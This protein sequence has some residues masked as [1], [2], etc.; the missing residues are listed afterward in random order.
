MAEDL[1]EA[2]LGPRLRAAIAA[3]GSQ[4]AFA[5]R[6]G[7]AASFI[8]EVAG[9]RR[10]FTDRILAAM[11]LRKVT[12]YRPLGAAG[13][14][15]LPSGL[16]RTDHKTLLWL[17]PDG[18]PRQRSERTGEWRPG[19]ADLRRMRALRLAMEMLDGWAATEAGLAARAEL[20][21]RWEEGD[22]G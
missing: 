16:T 9:G 6:V 5:R 17:R 22:A 18:T 21:A 7:V 13:A 15:A 2:D 3:A 10:N 12:V 8:S 11:G 4:E 14:A 1:Q 20:A 19:L